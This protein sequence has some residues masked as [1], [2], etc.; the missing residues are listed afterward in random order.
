M[1]WPLSEC[2]G[3]LYHLKSWKQ[4]F[5]LGTKYDKI[6]SE[7]VRMPHGRSERHIP[8]KGP[9]WSGCST[10]DLG[11]LGF[12]SQKGSQSYSSMFMFVGCVPHKKLAACTSTTVRIT[13]TAAGKQQCRRICCYMLL[14]CLLSLRMDLASDLE[15]KRGLY[16]SLGTGK[17]TQTCCIFKL[18]SAMS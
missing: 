14:P 13:L 4:E 16:H 17:K 15:N 7:D 10:Q 9:C 6:S 8:T 12:F 2:T 3:H 5:R 1:P 11:R 18:E